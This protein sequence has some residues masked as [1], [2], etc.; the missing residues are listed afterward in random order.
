MS[1]L[2]S[3]MKLDIPQS[4]HKKKKKKSFYALVDYSNENSIV[5]HDYIGKILKSHDSKL[6][7][8]THQGTCVAFNA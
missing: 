5:L 8:F 3:L 4:S 6:V 2:E 7:H 1:Q